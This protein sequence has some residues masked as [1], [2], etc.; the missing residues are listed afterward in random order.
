M[1]SMIIDIFDPK[2]RKISD[3]KYKRVP[4]KPEEY[5]MCSRC[6]GKGIYLQP[7]NCH[8]SE[9]WVHCNCSNGWITQGFV[10]IKNAVYRAK[11]RSR[12]II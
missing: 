9:G 1:N 4:L 7:E 11:A 2:I 8:E 10:K 5:R 12:K 6:N 3:A